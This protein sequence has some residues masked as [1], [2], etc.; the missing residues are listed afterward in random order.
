MLELVVVLIMFA[1]LTLSRIE[2]HRLANYLLL[3][4]FLG[5]AY[6]RAAQGRRA[7]TPTWLTSVAAPGEGAERAEA[8]GAAGEPTS[9]GATLAASIESA[10]LDGL[11]GLALVQLTANAFSKQLAKLLN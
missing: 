7:S 2:A 11:L 5:A 9:G 1:S 6:L 10:L 4:V 3:P 8:L